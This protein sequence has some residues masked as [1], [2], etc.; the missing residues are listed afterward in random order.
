MRPR[1]ATCGLDAVRNSCTSE[2]I[3]P[4]ITP[5][6]S[7]E[8]STPRIAAIATTNSARSPRQSCFNVESLNK[9]ATAT[10]TTAASTGC[11]KALKRWDRNRTTTKMIPAANA[12]ES[13]VCAPP[14]SLTRDCDMPP[15]IGKPRPIPAARFEAESARNS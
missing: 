5:R 2:I 8:P 4:I 11:G 9:L 13:G 12:P 10:N 14:P 1:K 7:P 15:L 3:A 6:S